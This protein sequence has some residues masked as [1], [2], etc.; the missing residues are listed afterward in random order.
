VSLENSPLKVLVTGGTGFVGGHLIT[1]LDKV[2]TAGSEIVVGAFRQENGWAG[3][4]E[5]PTRVPVR[6]IGLDVTD[7]ARVSDVIRAEQPTHLVHLAAVAAV[8]AASRDP[9]FAWNVNLNGTMNIALAVADECPGCRILFSSSSEVYGASFKAGVPLDET[10]LL[11]PANPY[12]ASKA[13]ADLMLGQMAL[14]GLNVARLRPFNHIGAGQNE[15]FAIPSFAAQI[16][17]IEHGLQEPVIRVGWLDSV[18]DFLDVGDV[19]DAYVRTIQR[20][21]DL[22]AGCIINLSSGVGRRIGDML[23]K[24]LAM[25]AVRIELVQDPARFR[26]SDTPL[27]AGDSSRARDLLGWKPQRNIDDTLHSVLSYW[28]TR[29]AH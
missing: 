13:A 4:F 12:A 22:P 20:A 27:V 15:Q 1:A 9:R 21:D 16:A 7:P 17:R 26:A 10:A 29:F 19:A 14:Q 18:R 2:L 6:V 5:L 3:N 8:T 28:R 11:Q 24:L 25:S 23:D